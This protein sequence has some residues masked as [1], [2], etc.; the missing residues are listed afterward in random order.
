MIRSM[1]GYA[2]RNI[3]SKT[4]RVKVSLKSLNHRFFDWSYKGA[5]LGEVEN[6]LRVLCQE[7]LQRGRIEASVDLSFPDP[8]SWDVAINE[9]LLE[10]ILGAFGRVS[11]RM[12]REVSFGLDNI[13][14][15]P[16]VV[17]LRRK[18][19]TPAETSF[20]EACFAR[21]LDE[22]LKVRRA[23]GR[24]IA[25]QL[26]T[27]LL[28]IGRAVRRV[29][30]LVKRQPKTFRKKLRVKVRE[31]NGAKPGSQE[32]LAE[33]VA[34]LTQRYDVAEEIARLKHHLGAALALAADA[35][36]EPAGRMLDFLTQE[37]TR[38]ANT[39]NSKSQDIGVTREGLLIK[40]EVESIRQQVQNIE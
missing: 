1:T 31:A 37:F 32:R 35:G 4:M 12:G 27:H 5:P 19:F 28:T 18:A 24:K 23:E 15:I 14:R 39:L 25:V 20:I 34:Y 10:K 33:E 3:A 17:E 6:R 38:E 2:E 36:G 7:K 22:V 9:G 11:A 30:V 29:E 13:F 21:T 26:R 16:Q 8:A 40:G